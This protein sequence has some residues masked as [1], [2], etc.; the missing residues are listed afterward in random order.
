LTVSSTKVT[1]Q[2]ERAVGWIDAHL[3]FGSPGISLIVI[4]NVQ[5]DE[6]IIP[7]R[8][9]DDAAIALIDA[10]RTQ[11]FILGALDGFVIDAGAAWV[12]LKLEHKFQSLGLHGRRQCGH[13]L[14][15]FVADNDLDIFDHGS[16]PLRADSTASHHCSPSSIAV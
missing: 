11:V 14:D 4:I 15:H 10:D 9:E 7:W 13:A 1:L 8:A 3:P 16:C 12:G 5:P 2:G 6:N